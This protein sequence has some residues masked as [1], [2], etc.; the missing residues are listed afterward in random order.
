MKFTIMY[1]V[2]RADEGGISTFT[3]ISNPHQPG[4]MINGFVVFTFQIPTLE[5]PKQAAEK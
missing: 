5:D 3:V 4:Y 2:T 1:Q